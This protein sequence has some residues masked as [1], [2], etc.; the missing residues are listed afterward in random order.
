[1]VEELKPDYSYVVGTTGKRQSKQSNKKKCLLKKGAI[2]TMENTE[3]E[4]SKT[5]DLH[6]IF[7]CGK[8]RWSINLS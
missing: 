2:G 3:L 5:L 8:K 4:L 7:D 1:M 6:R